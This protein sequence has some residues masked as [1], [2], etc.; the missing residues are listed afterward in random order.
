MFGMM[1]L[2]DLFVFYVFEK[3]NIWALWLDVANIIQ[4]E[5]YMENYIWILFRATNKSSTIWALYG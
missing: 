5:T 4:I 1:K 3:K 2:L